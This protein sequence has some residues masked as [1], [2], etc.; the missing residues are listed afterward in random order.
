MDTRMIALGTTMPSS[1]FV[2]QRMKQVEWFSLAS[3][4]EYLDFPSP[5]AFRV[6]IRR[7]QTHGGPHPKVHW[8]G[9]RMRFRRVDLDACV[10]PE[11]KSAASLQRSSTSHEPILHDSCGLPKVK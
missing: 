11:R 7:Q 5:R 2:G 3:A 6:W 9:K 4:A 10:E 1:A 8:L